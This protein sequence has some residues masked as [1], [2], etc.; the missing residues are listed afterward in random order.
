MHGSEFLKQISKNIE[1]FD[2]NIDRDGVAPSHFGDNKTYEVELFVNY[3]IC[4]FTKYKTENPD[5]LEL[6]TA[7]INYGLL[8][9]SEFPTWFWKFSG[10]AL[11][12]HKRIQSIYEIMDVVKRADYMLHW[13]QHMM[14][15][16]IKKKVENHSKIYLK[17]AIWI[18]GFE[19]IK[20]SDRKD[21]NKNVNNI[22]FKK[23]AFGQEFV[24]ENIDEGFRLC[25][26]AKADV[27][28][29]DPKIVYIL[30]LFSLVSKQIGVDDLKTKY[31]INE[32]IAQF[33]LDGFETMFKGVEA[34]E[35][36]KRLKEINEKIY[37]VEFQKCKGV[38]DDRAYPIYWF[39]D[40]IKS[41]EFIYDDIIGLK[42]L[43]EHPIYRLK[44]N[45]LGD[46]KF[47][48]MESTFLL[49]KNN[50]FSICRQVG[51]EECVKSLIEHLKWSPE[52]SLD[53][54]TVDSANLYYM[55]AT[56]VVVDGKDQGVLIFKREKDRVHLKG[57]WDFTPIKHHGNFVDQ[58]DRWFFTKI[59]LSQD[60]ESY[61]SLEMDTIRDSLK[62][63]AMCNI[64]RNGRV[65]NGIL[66]VSDL[67]IPSECNVHDI[68]SEIK[69]CALN[70]GYSDMKLV[71]YE[72]VKDMTKDQDVFDVGN[73]RIRSLTPLEVSTDSNYV[74]NDPD[75]ETK[76]DV[77]GDETDFGISYLGISIKEILESRNLN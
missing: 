42:Y 12:F 24:G 64:Y 63:F 31:G 8:Y 6:L 67:K 54:K 26:C 3:D 14:N 5:W 34:E 65:N 30:N 50:L 36:C 57:V 7:F 38:W 69:K 53:E 43:Y 58:L 19:E 66:G 44:E 49:N 28:T 27:L 18:S 29:V 16:Y 71:T 33:V 23:S 25:T 56:V 68:L 51:K 9:P 59:G 22:K 62:P 4:N 40:D 10:D 74:I 11:T 20:S 37:F 55:I 17:A 73:V 70:S 39:I 13:L 77:K 21:I 15:E 75:Y 61:F 41:K 2:I 35:L 76:F 32:S 60:L 45:Y 1:R 48:G 47:D 72:M 46:K 52:T